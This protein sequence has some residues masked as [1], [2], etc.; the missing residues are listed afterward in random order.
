MITPSTDGAEL[1]RESVSDFPAAHIPVA[2]KR[3]SGEPTNSP[4]IR[5]SSWYTL[6]SCGRTTLLNTLQTYKR[7]QHIH[8]YQY[9]KIFLFF[10]AVRS[11]ERRVGKEC[12]A[13]SYR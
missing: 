2:R 1:A 9:L 6:T 10:F 7:V 12:R 3:R 11:E 13:V 4:A 5:N 8:L